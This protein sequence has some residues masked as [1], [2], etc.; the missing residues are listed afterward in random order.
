MP[1]H[2]TIT[3]TLLEGATVALYRGVRQRDGTPVVIKAFRAES[4]G[5]REIERLRHE[6]EIA[7]QLDSSYLLKPY[8]LDRQKTQVWLILEDFDGNPLSGQLGRPLETDR[9]LILPGS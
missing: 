9:F 3:A 5:Q 8:A 7:R 6:F 2:F 4:P 1:D